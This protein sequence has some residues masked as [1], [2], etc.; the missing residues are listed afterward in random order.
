M[1]E[2][3]I[4]NHE[5]EAISKIK[6]QNLMISESAENYVR[7]L[8]N[9]SDP[10]VNGRGIDALDL[11]FSPPIFYEIKTGLNHVNILDTQFHYQETDGRSYFIM[12]KREDRVNKFNSENSLLFNF[13]GIYILPID[14]I[15][16][17]YI[18]QMARNLAKSDKKLIEKGRYK[19]FAN[20]YKVKKRKV[21]KEIQ[22]T[23]KRIKEGEVIL[24][25]ERKRVSITF[26]Q[27]RQIATGCGPYYWALKGTSAFNIHH[28]WGNIDGPYIDLSK[29]S[30]SK[31]FVRDV[32]D[33]VIID[34]ERRVN[35]NKIKELNE[36]KRERLQLYNEIKEKEKDFGWS[37]DD[38]SKLLAKFNA[39]KKWQYH[40]HDLFSQPEEDLPF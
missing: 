15:M 16:E 26:D 11:S 13:G 8:L 33:K 29:K 22:N 2:D 39:L 34:L 27:L 19:N 38:D 6:S 40:K 1:N 25:E 9:L 18:S 20:L 17:H 28:T 24:H 30:V 7:S 23:T 31:I 36:M 37:L 21:K 3:S 35:E 14:I 4:E 12:I 5:E 10:R 32:D